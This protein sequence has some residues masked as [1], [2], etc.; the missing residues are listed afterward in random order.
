[1]R[2]ATQC[3][4]RIIVLLSTVL[5]LFSAQ[6][7]AAAQYTLL[8]AFSGMPSDGANPQYGSLATDGTVLYGLTLN[9]GTANNGALFKI[10]VSGSGYQVLH[11]FAG[12]AFGTGSTNDGARPFG[13][14]LLIGSTLYGTTIFG[15]TNGSGTLFKINTDGSG[16]QLLH[17]FGVNTLAGDGSMPQCTLV[18]D[19]TTLFGMTGNGSGLANSLGT[20][21]KID[22]NGANYQILHNF[23]SGTDNGA[24][25]QG[26][27]ILSGGTL[28]GM[29]QFGGALNN[30]VIFKIGANGSGF[31]VI[32][33]FTG[34]ATDGALPYGSL[35]ISGST[36]Y[37]MTSSGGA[38]GAGTAFRIDTSGGSFSIL[39]NFSSADTWS[40]FGDLTLS[41]STLFG[42][43]K[44]SG[45]SLL[46]FGTIFQVN[47]DG[48]GFQIPHVFSFPNPI[49][50][51]STPMGSL[52]LLG[53][54]FYGMTQN[55][56]SANNA[57][58]LFSFTPSGGGG[59]P[60]T[61]LRVNLLPSGAVKAGAQWKLNAGTLQNSGALLTGVNPGPAVIVYQS[62]TGWTAPAPQIISITAG[63]TNTITGTYTA[64][65][66]TLPTL[67]VISPTSKTSVNSNLF[68]ATGTASDNVGLALVYYQLNGG[69]WTAASSGDS[70][71][72]WTAPNLTLVPGINVIKFYAKDLSGNVSTTNSVSFTYIVSAPIGI[73]LNPPG[74]GTIKGAVNGQLLQIGKAYSL[75]VKAAKGYQFL[76]WTGGTNS[77]ATKLAFVMVSN[78]TF[79]ANFRD[80]TRPVDVI[81]SPT[82]G[83]VVSTANPTATGRAMDNTG[84]TAVWCQVNGGAWFQAN[85]SDGT[86]W[87]TASLSTQLLAGPN[88]IS[89]YA[90]DAAGNASLTNTIAFTYVVQPTMEWAPD[91]MNGILADVTPVGGA[92]VI[93]GFDLSAF[94]QTSASNDGDPDDYG[95]GT[96]TYSKT[97]TNM[98]QLSLAFTKPPG[99]SN[100]V[101]PL[102]LV[103]TNHYA[104][105]LTN[106]SGDSGGINLQ[107]ATAFV[108]ATMVGKTLTGV[109]S[110]SA[111]TTK[112]KFASA[113]AFSLT[114]SGGARS[115]NYTLARL[116]PTC[117]ALTFTYT[118][119]G[120]AGRTSYLQ[121]TFSTATGGTFFV[122]S[123]DNTGALEDI[124]AGTFTM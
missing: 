16:F 6:S 48:S 102:T 105:Y 27:L 11:S 86:N 56:G 26:S 114:S 52:L 63:I 106:G 39:H 37:G 80:I 42:M 7:H 91:S 70:F 59:G 87:Q 30:G 88:S 21:F 2:F 28:Y 67:K 51:G 3:T 122:M 4:G 74:A 14:P 38:S 77:T 82:K 25:P 100:N 73:I 79:T 93:V 13:A 85:L 81:L 29:T 9:G 40:P 84:V 46:G 113:T 36:L 119:S 123:F 58:A 117:E 94:A 69:A 121:L 83:Q 96:Y 76:N 45:L 33:P 31:Q 20:I 108:P 61:A 10:N 23:G 78:L 35:I 98:A 57:G 60:V 101:G 49:S 1:M 24:S 103:F 95:G 104:G 41:G 99:N 64:A 47:T 19:G 43:A 65:D 17:S 97:D 112:V 90:L 32:H 120:A 107:T 66:I 18:T 110:Q 92:Q 15:G 22:S 54:T 34:T 62:V 8:H 115:G 50:D 111:N 118:S 68:T 12:L 71:A 75:S 89:A 44:N 53:S 55:G 109:S 124:D 5:L 72:N 116:S